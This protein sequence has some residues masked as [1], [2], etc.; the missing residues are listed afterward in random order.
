MERSE[1]NYDF[2]VPARRFA[3]VRPQYFEMK[4]RRQKDG[5]VV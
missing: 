4:F 5:R 1:R 3:V 2:E